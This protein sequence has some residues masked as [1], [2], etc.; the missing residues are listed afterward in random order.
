MLQ[1]LFHQNKVLFV[2]GGRAQG[3]GNNRHLVDCRGVQA[4]RH[5]QFEPL[6]KCQLDVIS[7]QCVAS[8][9]FSELTCKLDYIV[10]DFIC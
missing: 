6:F 4:R 3:F 10:D 2:V 5:L 9:V 1:S 7:L 8:S